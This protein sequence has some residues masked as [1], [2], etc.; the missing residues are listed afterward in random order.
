MTRRF[1]YAIA[2]LVAPLIFAVGAHAAD[3][4]A[5]KK[6]MNY[7]C[8]KAGNKNKAACKDK[9]AA[10]TPATKATPAPKTTP[11][12]PA[13]K[14]ATAPAAP[15][16]KAAPAA[17][18]AKAAPVAPAAT[19]A[20]T[21]KKPMTYDCTKEGNKNKTACK[22]Q[23]PVAPTPQP[24][25]AKAS[26]VPSARTPAVAAATTAANPNIVEWKTTTGKIVHYDCSKA[27]NKT[28]QA[29]KGK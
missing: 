9:D 22:T 14:T 20:A 18:A 4:P 12:T 16:A 8:S 17:P 5:A 11:A 29:C 24:A 26:S 19:A 15:A 1:G 10:A 2:A 28:K 3:A 27:G 7:D 25:P 23:A 13:T 6:P 21:G